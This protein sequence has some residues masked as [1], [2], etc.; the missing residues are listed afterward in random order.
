MNIL[1]EV[2]LFSGT[3]IREKSPVDTTGSHWV[4]NPIDKF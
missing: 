2:F 1:R 4:L 3:R